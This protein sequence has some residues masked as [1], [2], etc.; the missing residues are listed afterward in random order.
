MTPFILGMMGDSGSGKSTMADAVAALLGRDRVA[1]LRLDDYH[2]FTREERRAR[3]VTALNPMVHNFPLMQ[4]HLQLIRQGRPIRNRSYDHSNGTFG[5]IR[6]IEPREVVLVRGLSGYPNDQMR[7][8]YNLAVFLRPEAELLFRWKRRRDVHSRGYAET[9]VLKA[10]AHH[11][12]DSKQ[13]VLPQAERAD[14]VVRHELPD[15]D[16]ADTDVR[17]SVVLRRQA[18]EAVVGSGTLEGLP[19]IEVER[20]DDE[21]VVTAPAEL[22]PGALERWGR[23]LFPE[24]YASERIGVY[25]DDEGALRTRPQLGVVEVLIARLVDL[26]RE[27]QVAGAGSA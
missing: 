11:L 1:D 6:V 13:Y 26:L 5:P 21:T 10:I 9:D 18:A 8:L 23:S 15:P 20:S 19:G 25:I 2:R 7:A 4:E 22:D 16:A 24:T 14:V 27:G 12:L 3:G 17:T